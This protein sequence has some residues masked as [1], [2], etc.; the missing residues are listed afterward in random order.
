M[1]VL[2]ELRISKVLSQAELAEKAGI[3]RDTVIHLEIGKQKPTFKTVRKLAKALGVEPGDI[4]FS[5]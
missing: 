5:V 4:D 3:S 1:T 2:K